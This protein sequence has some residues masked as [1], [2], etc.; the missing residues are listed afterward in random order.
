MVK[1]S[2]RADKAAEHE[3]IFEEA[4]DTLIA[5]REPAPI[6]TGG[7]ADELNS[8]RSYESGEKGQ[9]LWHWLGF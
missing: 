9:G 8:P 4:I 1:L 3:K 7:T 2:V 6:C 5:F